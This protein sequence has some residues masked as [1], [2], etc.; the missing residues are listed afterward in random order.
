MSK[1]NKVKVS[2]INLEIDGKIIE[3]T[4]T[5]VILDTAEGRKSIPARLFTEQASLLL[6]QGSSDG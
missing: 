4:F 6:Q 1:Q 5:A 3:L 2:K